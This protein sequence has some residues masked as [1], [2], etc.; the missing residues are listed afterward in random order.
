[1]IYIYNVSPCFTIVFPLIF[2]VESLEKNLTTLQVAS[3]LKG[4]GLDC[5][6]FNLPVSRAVNIWQMQL[7]H[8]G[9]VTFCMF[10][11]VLLDIF[12]TQSQF[13]ARAAPTF[14]CLIL[15]F[16]T[17]RIP[18]QVEVQIHSDTVDQNVETIFPE[19]IR[20]SKINKL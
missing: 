8:A 5:V 15:P 14:Q 4:E 12:L 16:K 10:C 3:H 20:I 19:Y 18:A 6:L 11:R 13:Q 2:L 7:G 17:S 9:T 1:M